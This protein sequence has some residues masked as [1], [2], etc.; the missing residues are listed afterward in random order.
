MG[1]TV[2]INRH[3]YLAF[4]V[5]WEGNESH[6]GTKLKDTPENR[7]KVEARARVIDQEI[8]DGAFEYLHWFPT[9]NLAGS[10]QPE[11]AET[12]TK[13]ITVRGFFSTWGKAVGATDSEATTPE[14]KQGRFVTRKWASNR[15]SFIRKHVLPVLGALRLDSLA[16]VHLTDLQRR[17]VAKALKPATVDGV[18]H[19]ALRGMLRDAE[20]AGYAVPDLRRLYDRRFVQRLERAGDPTEIDPFTEDERDLLLNAFLAEQ[21]Q[22]YPLVAHQFWT[23]ARPS[24]AAGLRWGDVDLQRRRITVRRSR[25]LGRDSRPKTGK[26]K[27]SVVIH[28]PLLEILRAIRP[29][30]AAN[31]AFVFVTTTGAP[32]DQANFYQRIWVPALEQLKVR[33]R[34]FYNTRHTYISYMIAIGASP[35][36]VHRQTG[37][38]LEMIE[39]HYGSVAVL[40]D[41]MD[42][43]I[44][45]RAGRKSRN[46]AGTPSDEPPR[47]QAAAKEK[48]S[49]PQRVTS[50][51]GDRGRTGDVQLGKLA[52]YR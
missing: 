24:E 12:S 29:K 32:I 7:A 19:S 22:F 5:Y 26:S 37:T 45:E 34:A 15:A 38:S 36:F 25:V 35:L 43:L 50:R 51:A 31:D 40:A 23:G 2:R 10:L 28:E 52:F 42:E 49:P 48:P 21:P 27:R 41:E 4:R 46:P 30:Q 33:A 3:G 9:G 6:E 1:C 20:A 47:P 8:R 44:S 16:S 17:L 13:R 18:I 11:R 14:D 39:N